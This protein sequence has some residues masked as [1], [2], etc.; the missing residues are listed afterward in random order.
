MDLF[1]N[2]LCLQKRKKETKEDTEGFLDKHFKPML[3][4]F[5]LLFSPQLFLCLFCVSAQSLQKGLL[6]SFFFPPK[7]FS[8]PCPASSYAF[9]T[10]NRRHHVALVHE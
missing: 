3:K 4:P 2:K 5:F 8:N 9:I 10:K 7:I 6:T 1:D